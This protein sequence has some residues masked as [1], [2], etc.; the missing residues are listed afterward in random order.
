MRSNSLK[1][2]RINFG[3]TLLDKSVIFFVEDTGIGVK[4]ELQEKIFER[5]T[6][7]EETFKRNYGGNGLGLA[8]SKGIVEC[9]G[10]K[11]WLDTSY[12]PG[13]RFCFIIPC[14]NE[15]SS[16]IHSGQGK[17]QHKLS[18]CVEKPG[19]EVAGDRCSVFGNRYSVAVFGNRVGNPARASGWFQRRPWQGVRLE[20]KVIGKVF[21]TYR[22]LITAY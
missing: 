4:N 6:Q 19:I 18:G 9:L 21:L 10:G 2:A 22:P 16:D 11:I 12:S 1:K 7:S 14:A 3:Y 13:A 17:Y 15:E 8:I 20:K 5:F